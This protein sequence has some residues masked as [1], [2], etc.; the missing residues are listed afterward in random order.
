MANNIMKIS[1]GAIAGLA[2]G[3]LSGNRIA[4]YNLDRELHLN[5]Q[6]AFVKTLER[7]DTDKNGILED[8]EIFQALDLDGDG[9]L[10]RPEKERAYKIWEA[11]EKYGIDLWT[12]R[13]YIKDATKKD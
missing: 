3:L 9:T 8:T 10:S 4:T 1:G 5:P 12:V 6:A 7:V 13:T 11:Y 2:I